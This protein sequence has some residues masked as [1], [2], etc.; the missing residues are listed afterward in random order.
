[1]ALKISSGMMAGFQAQGDSLCKVET[2]VRL[3]RKLA[4]LGPAARSHIPGTVD[5]AF[6]Y[7]QQQRFSAPAT[8][9]DCVTRAMLTLLMGDQIH[10]ILKGPLMNERLLKIGHRIALFNRRYL[11]TLAELQEGPT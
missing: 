11:A 1:M 8:V 9:A 6:A 10:A 7:I 2:R 3:R 5:N 4:H